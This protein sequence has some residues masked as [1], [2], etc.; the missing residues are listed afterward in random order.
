MLKQNVILA[1]AMDRRQE[2]FAMGT[3]TK[4]RSGM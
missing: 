4:Q 1:G 2:E 3:G